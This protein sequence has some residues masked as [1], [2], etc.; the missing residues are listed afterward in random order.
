[1]SFST[2]NLPFFAQFCPFLG[3]VVRKKVLLTCQ[4][5]NATPSKTCQWNIATRQTLSG[6]KCYSSRNSSGKMC[7][8]PKLVRQNMLLD[9]KSIKSIKA[10]LSND[11]VALFPW[12]VWESSTFFLISFGWSSTFSWQGLV[13]SNI[14][15]TYMCSSISVFNLQIFKQ[16]SHFFEYVL[17]YEWAK[18]FFI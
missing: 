16:K 7:Y 4:E 14:F 18:D 10:N 13:S 2:L 11:W 17:E 5:K 15:L 8:S 9:L 3:L 6:K 1:M 12:Q